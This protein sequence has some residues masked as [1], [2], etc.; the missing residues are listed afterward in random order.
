MAR[1]LVRGGKMLVVTAVGAGVAWA[2]WNLKQAPIKFP[3]L[4]NYPDLSQ[5][6]NHM[7]DQLTEEV[8]VRF[9][10]L[11]KFKAC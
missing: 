3:P 5:H 9:C 1:V 10:F 4:A 2:A 11:T 6:N 7:A 8:S